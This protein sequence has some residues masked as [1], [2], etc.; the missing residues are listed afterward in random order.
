[1]TL[2]ENVPVSQDFRKEMNAWMLSFFGSTNLV[3]DGQVLFVNGE[4]VG[5]SGRYL[6]VNPRTYDRMKSIPS[7]SH[8][9]ASASFPMTHGLL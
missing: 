6:L 1:M 2:S 8:Y 3:E 4:Y 9:S 5:S 7:P